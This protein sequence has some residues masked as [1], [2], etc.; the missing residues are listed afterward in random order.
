M[1]TEYPLRSIT[2]KDEYES[3][4]SDLRDNEQLIIAFRNSSRFTM[5]L[6]ILKMMALLTEP[7][8]S[9]RSTV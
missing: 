7:Y 8:R 1:N 2:G 5:V 9:I 3:L 6:A 4:C